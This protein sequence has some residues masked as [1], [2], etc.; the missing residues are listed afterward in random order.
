MALA[1]CVQRTD[2]LIIGGGASG[3]AAGIQAARLGVRTVIAEES[4]WL[5]G[6]LTG[7]GVSAVDGNFHMRSGIFGE[8]IDSLAWRYG[9]LGGLQTGWVSNVLFEP[10]VGAEVLAN[11]AARE[12]AL[13]VRFG[14]R[15]VSAEKLRNGWRVTLENAGG[16]YDIKAKVLI[17]GTELGDVAKACGAGYDIGMDSRHDTHES[18]APEAGN[19]IVQDL[20][21]CMTLKDYGP[22]AD[23]TIARP[24]DY[25]PEIYRNCCVNPHNQ[26]VEPNGNGGL[27][28]ADTKQTVSTPEMMLSYGRLPR[29]S[30]GAQKYM[31]NWPGDGNDVYVNIV[32]A[33][34]E[35]RAEALDSAKRVSLGFLYFMQTELGYRNLGLADDEYPTSDLMPFIPYHRESR[36]VHGLVRFTLDDAAQPFAAQTPLYRTGIASGDYPVDHHH[37][38]YEAWRTLPKLDFYPIPSYNVPMGVL[39][40]KGVDDFVVAEKSV[41]VTNLINGATRLQ[42]M[43]VQFGQVA[44]VI[45]ALS[46]AKGV[47]PAAIDV[48]AVQDILIDADVYIMPYKDLRPCDPRFAACMR[49][50]ATGILRGMGQPRAWSNETWFRIS[51]PLLR[52]EIFLEDYY[53]GVELGDNAS[54]VTLAGAV[55]ILSAIKGATL[56]PSVLSEA[57]LDASDPSRIISRVEFAVLLD[58]VLD[59]F[60]SFRVDLNGNVVK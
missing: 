27:R 44:G 40:P 52:S 43:T 14:E 30:G 18:I 10:S 2:V 51:D 29:H 35:R 11:I 1:S 12:P 34:P 53:P 23:M 3:T 26:D 41:S 6:M 45:A 32:D 49:I 16:Q 4:V 50:G 54:P 5:G 20:T 8:F 31:I 17:D 42:P 33:S 28:K 47:E 37:F 9:S 7:A 36:R 38:R 19:D 56:A 13:D 55:E 60:H 25:R 24:A 39:L 59:P 57:G 15:F 46:V 21:Y 58:H 22:D 48:R